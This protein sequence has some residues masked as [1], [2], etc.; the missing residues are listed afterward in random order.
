MEAPVVMEVYRPHPCVYC[1]GRLVSSLQVDASPS[2]PSPHP[3]SSEP[4]TFTISHP[5]LSRISARHE[6]ILLAHLEGSCVTARASRF[7]RKLKMRQYQRNHGYP[8]FDLD[9]YI[10]RSL[11]T[12]VKYVINKEKPYSDQIEPVVRDMSPSPPPHSHTYHSVLHHISTFPR[13]SASNPSPSR[14]LTSCLSGR[15]HSL[16][17]IHSPYTARILKPYIFRS[18]EI[19]PPQVCRLH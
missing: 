3:S 7:R 11:S 10:T 16:A 19:R 5:S 13:L 6:A 12:T 2:P 9:H 18:A 15:G 8:T 1:N 17:P 14:Q 4:T